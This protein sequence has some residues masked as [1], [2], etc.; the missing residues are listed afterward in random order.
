MLPH[1]LPQVDPTVCV[2]AACVCGCGC[3]MLQVLVG[4]GAGLPEVDGLGR[5]ALHFAVLYGH[6]DLAKW[7]MSQG[8]RV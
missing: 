5:N 1:G 2:A 6:L 4:A 8:V 3:A 7:L